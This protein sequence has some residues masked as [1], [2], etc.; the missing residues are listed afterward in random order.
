MKSDSDRRLAWRGERQTE[1]RENDNFK[2]RSGM[3]EYIA[4]KSLFSL[5]EFQ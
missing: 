4:D 2:L 1:E 5:D 3:P